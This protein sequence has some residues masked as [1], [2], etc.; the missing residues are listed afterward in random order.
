MGWSGEAW[1][2]LAILE[3]VSKRTVGPTV[4]A[5]FADI[6]ESAHERLV[7]QSVDGLLSLLPRS[8]FNDSVPH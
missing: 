7:A 1:L 5:Y 3:H 6:N 8:I 4:N 2:G